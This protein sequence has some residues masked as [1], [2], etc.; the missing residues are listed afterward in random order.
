MT[1]L[2]A[3]DW[4]RVLVPSVPVVETIVRGS[5][6]YMTLFLMLRFV[7]QRESGTVGITDMLL[8]VLIADA[9]QNAMA[10]DYHSVPDGLLLVGVILFWSYALDWLAFHL[11]RL[12]PII[13]PPPLPLVRHGQVLR[14]NLERELISEDELRSQLRAQGVDDLRTVRIACM[15]SDGAISVITEGPRSKPR[16]RRRSAAS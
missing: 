15:E 9:A 16:R 6:V 11:P 14:R 1:A 8:I 2:D 7:A 5:V 3:V 12:R 4:N 13:R 10:G